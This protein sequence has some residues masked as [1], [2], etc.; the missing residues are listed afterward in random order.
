MDMQNFLRPEAVESMFVLYQ[1]TGDSRY[2]EWAWDIFQA[3]EK[4]AFIP[5]G[6]YSSVLDVR[7]HGHPTH[8]DRMESFYLSETLK[9]LFLLFSDNTP[10]PLDKWVFNTQAHPL[11]ITPLVMQ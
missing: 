10:L 5:S 4:A 7:V 8:K 2:Q 11:P 1:V 9:Y 6:G 3:F